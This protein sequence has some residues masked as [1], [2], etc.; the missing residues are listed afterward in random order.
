M[1]PMR[2]MITLFWVFVV[3]MLL[4]QFYDYNQNLSNDTLVAPR[5]QHYYYFNTNQNAVTAVTTLPKA[6]DGAYLQQI[7]YTVNDHTPI[8][9]E[10]TATSVIK[11]RGTV[12]A[13]HIQIW[14]RPYRG[15]QIADE[16]MGAPQN[17]YLSDNDPLA[18]IGEWVDVPDLG[19][20]ETATVSATFLRKPAITPGG[21]PS[22]N[23]TFTPG[24]AN[25]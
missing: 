18:Q 21:N 14:I 22:P 23:I 13:T 9:N 24:T 6:A 11:N 10:F 3:G 17:T 19:P 25:P 20:G 16:E 12:K 1:N 15:I 7:G 4:W 8:Q 5:P 2:W